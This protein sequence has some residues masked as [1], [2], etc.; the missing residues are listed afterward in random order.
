[1]NQTVNPII[2]VRPLLLAVL[3]AYAVNGAA[4]EK[5]LAA[6]VVS[7]QA[8]SDTTTQVAG[9]ELDIRAAR[10]V[11]DIFQNET[12]IAVGGGGNAIT[13][14]IYVRNIEDTLLTVTLDG[15]PQGG[16]IFH[17]QGRILINPDM[18]K[19]IEIDKGGTVASVGPGG[20]AGS[21]RMTTKD[22]RDLLR[23]EQ[24]I[25]G[26]LEAGTASFAGQ[27]YGGALYGRAGEDLDF[28]LYANHGE[29]GEYRDGNGKVQ[30]NSG[31]EQ[32]SG[33]FKANWRLAP[34]HALYL[35][36]Q[37]LEDKGIRFLRPHLVGYTG[38]QVSVPQR[39]EQST[40][41]GGYRFSGDGFIQSADLGFFVDD[42][43]NSRTNASAAFGKPSGYVY[44]EKLEAQGLNL[45]LKSRLGEA[46]L[47]Y[48]F[49]H[50][51]RR[52]EALNP[53]KRGVAGNT[54]REESS[55]SGAFLEGTLPLGQRLALD[56]GMRYDWY[57]YND[58]HGQKFSSDGLSPNAALTLQANDELS[59]RFGGSRTV[60]GAGLKEAFMIDNGPGTAIYRNE[61][62][63]KA[64]TADNLEL[65]ANYRSGGFDFKA[66]VF[67]MNIADYITMVFDAAAANPASRRNVGKV[68]S[69]GYELGAG[70]RA[71]NFRS[72]VSVFHSQ[73]KLN[74]ADLGDGDFSL[75]V[76]TGRTWLFTAGYAL[77]AWNVDLGWT[78]KYVESLRYQPA[79]AGEQ[80]KKSY[81]VHDL[82][83]NWLPLGKDRLRLT[84]SVRNLFDKFYYDQSTYGYSASAGQYLGYADPGRQVRLD[85][86]WRF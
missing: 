64:E 14:K 27:R 5:S 69:N 73:P 67:R 60:R 75:G 44:G 83:V 77:P 13:Q 70:W 4:D 35:G 28:M 45:L 59:F 9:R 21:V 57:S 10:D 82:Y 55:V 24:A 6:T 63:L 7:E 1:M 19:R 8:Y 29:S 86:N 15:V 46:F 68:E 32:D 65:S 78:G 47:R 49:N 71:G 66:A 30:K 80:Q 76:S 31:S 61:K 25:G 53:S 2:G 58:N 79:G 54:G 41:T 26:M 39:L 37:A 52:A 43:K 16:N 84:L 62:N 56:A 85:M 34:G 81:S 11:R 51:E 23:P 12:G 33:L 42:N 20:L 50:H 36:Y 48:G 17:H 40:L 38:A 72:G 18:L 3:A 74:G 22:A